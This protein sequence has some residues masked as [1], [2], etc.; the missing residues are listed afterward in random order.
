V[1]KFV[2]EYGE[3]VHRLLS[4][5]GMAPDLFYLGRISPGSEFSVVVMSYIQGETVASV[6]GCMEVSDEVYQGVKEALNVLHEAGLV[7]GDLRRPNIMTDSGKV[8]LIDYDWAGLAGTARYPSFLNPRTAYPE[9]VGP[10]KK[11]TKEH[12]QW[13]LEELRRSMEW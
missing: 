6:F 7:Y 3:D 2:R 10:R 12:D 8:I 4:S 13:M 11:I 9:G 5:R 1:V